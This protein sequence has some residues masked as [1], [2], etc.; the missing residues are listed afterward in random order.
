MLALGFV[1]SLVHARDGW[2]AVVPQGLIL[3]VAMVV[4]RMITG[5]LGHASAHRRSEKVLSH[6]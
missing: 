3:S 1:N 2:T 5:W 6:G 4:V